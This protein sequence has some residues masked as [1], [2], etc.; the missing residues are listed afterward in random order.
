MPLSAPGF[1]P[2]NE[3]DILDGLTALATSLM[4]ADMDTGETSIMGSFL[5]IIANKFA[6]YQQDIEAIFLA[7][8]YD[9]A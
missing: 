4:G 2:E 7:W 8:F 5:R 1:E 9:S 3:A 6:L